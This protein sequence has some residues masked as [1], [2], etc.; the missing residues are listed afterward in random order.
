MKKLLY[1]ILGA[2]VLVNTS[3]KKSYL[4]V[5]SPSAVD[6]DFVFSSPQETYK[7]LVG[8]YTIWETA[9]Q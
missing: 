8:C 2:L 7:V 1:I 5:T 3:C 9:K 6:Q 4:N